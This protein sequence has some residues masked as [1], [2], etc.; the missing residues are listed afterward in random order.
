M[1]RGNPDVR[2]SALDHGQYGSQHATDGSDFLPIHIRG[3]GHSKKV[4]EQFIRPVN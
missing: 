1:I 3:G 2:G 4:T